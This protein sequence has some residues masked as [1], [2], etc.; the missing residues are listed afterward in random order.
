MIDIN[1]VNVQKLKFEDLVR[2]AVERNDNEAQAWLTEQFMKQVERKGK[3]GTIMAYQPVNSYRMEYLTK[4]C[5]YTKKG[6]VKLT[7]E[8]KR[9]KHI[10][11][12]F[13]AARAK[14]EAKQ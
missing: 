8:E 4:F 6:T 5:G 1:N 7:A 9:K 10:E 13:A 2:D 12:M 11:D 14:M 3:N